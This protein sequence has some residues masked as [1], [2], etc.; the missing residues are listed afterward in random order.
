MLEYIL[1]GQGH[2]DMAQLLLRNNF[3]CGALRPFVGSDGRNYITLNQGGTPQTFVTNA[4]AT[5][6]KDDWLAFDNAIIKA[7]KPRLRAFGDLRAAGLVYNIPNGMGKMF[8][9]HETQSDI[10]EATVSMDGTKPS[11]GDRPVFTLAGLPLPIIHKEFQINLRQ[12]LASRNGGSPLDTTTAELAAR[13]VAEEAEK[14]TLGVSSSFAYGSYYVYGYT[15]FP[16]RL[17]YTLADPTGVG[18][19]PAD[20]VADFLAMINAV[21]AAYHYG[22]FVA[23]HAPNWSQYMDDDYSA[24]KGDNTLRDRLKKIDGIQDVRRA[25]YLE[26][27]DIVLVQQTADVARAVVG[28]DVTTVQ[29]Q[30]GDGMTLHFKVMAIMVPQL[31]AD[32]NGNTGIIHGSV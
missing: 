25:D 4:P 29:W 27:Y 31:R 5:L 24:A 11:G 23:Y 13:R 16:S 20:L 14:L 18:W 15:N 2:G 30:S 26:N 28:Q 12:L 6:R 8:L 32:H 22:P 10:T 7:A 3:D 1:N 17:T 21:A 9:E 19:T